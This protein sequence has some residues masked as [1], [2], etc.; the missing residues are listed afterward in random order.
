MTESKV[1]S[2]SFVIV[3]G[4][5]LKELALKGN[6]LLVY[7][8]IYGFT[9]TDNACFSGSLKYLADWTNS[10]RQGVLKCLQSLLKKGYIL[11]REIF[12]N[13]VKYCEYRAANVKGVLS[14]KQHRTK[15]FNEVLN[16]SEPPVKQSLNNNIDNNINNSIDNILENA[17]NKNKKYKSA[18]D[19]EF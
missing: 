2:E 7:A 8:V 16:K 19:C 4:F 15:K 13:G 14:K 11:K 1:A 3:H 6:E 12:V 5:M 17:L 10:T 18:K 9:K